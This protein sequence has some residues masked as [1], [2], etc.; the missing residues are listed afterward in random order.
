MTRH[1]CRICHH[2]RDNRVYT[3]REMM[4]GTREQFEYFQCSN[5]NCLQ[6]TDI[7]DDLGRF[8]PPDYYSLSSSPDEP[9]SALKSFLLKQR[10]RY[11]LWG[12]GHKL[13]KILSKFVQMPY[14][15]LDEAIPVVELLKIAGISHYNARF[16]DIGCGTRSF[17]L[18]TLQTMGFRHLTG[19]DPF[20]DSN[21]Q[22]NNISIYK[23]KNSIFGPFDLIS[24]HHSLEHIPDQG[25][26]L[27]FASKLLSPNG[28][29]LIR[30]PTVSSYVWNKYGTDWVEMDPPRHLYL[31]S[32]KSIEM[33][34][35][36]AGL[37]LRHVLCDSIPF[38]FYGSEQY[39][40]DIPLADERSLWNNP[41]SDIFTS[42]ELATFRHQADHVN[43]TDQCG[44]ACFFFTKQ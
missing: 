8:Y 30:I 40:R 2:R 9:P 4:F 42:T 10:F 5:C 22:T 31:H 20:I 32:R 19:F 43:Q 27:A 36:K 23:Y 1:V 38:E 41:R 44:R 15:R 17:W 12:R 13:N 24:F 6:I 21:I 33:A 39:R 11:A 26:A 29:I 34:A 28:V 25:A 37:R 3:A 35:N 7:P 14:I 18:S 16:L